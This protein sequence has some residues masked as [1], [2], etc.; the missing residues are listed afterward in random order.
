MSQR[1]SLLISAQKLN[2]PFPSADSSTTKL[3]TERLLQNL[4]SVR[5]VAIGVQPGAATFGL[6]QLQLLAESSGSSAV[7]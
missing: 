7:N 6:Q 1:P 3:E 2:L 4:I 5:M